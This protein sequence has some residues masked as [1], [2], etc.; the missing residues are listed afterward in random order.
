MVLDR[1]GAQGVIAGRAR[2]VMARRPIRPA[3]LAALLTVACAG[4]NA[5]P[6]AGTAPA[7]P[8]P[9][10]P[11]LRYETPQD[12]PVN[13]WWVPTPDGGLVVFDALRTVSD[14]R[15]AAAKLHDTGR[16]VRA[17]LLTHPHPDHVTGLATLKAAFPGAP[18]YSTAEATQYLAGKGK[19]LLALNVRSRAPG[20]AT[21][22]VPAPDVLLRDRERVVIGGLAI[23][24][25]LMGSGESPAATV[26][27]LPAAHLLVVG[28]ILTPG[29]VPLLA[30]GRTAAWLA[31]IA[32]LRRTFPPETR[33]LPGHGPEIHLWEAAEWQEGYL[34]AFRDEV[35]RAVKEA[36]EDGPC[37]SAAEARRI[38]ASVALAYPTQERVAR[39]PPEA[40]DAL[41]VE[42]VAWELT[43]RTC[44]G[45]QNPIR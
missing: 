37:V 8:P 32:A 2:G 39:M 19:E 5:A 21:D 27:H 13:S 4:R 24:P 18:V 11:P 3:A 31:Q 30:A 10:S 12:A 42:G 17:I 25:H 34:L 15:A 36:S 44:P 22:E 26:Y 23:E 9:A 6:A 45:T 33:V 28:D 41:N 14:A 1:A 40:L 38:L 20:D 43:G 7:A 29:R 35:R 16:P